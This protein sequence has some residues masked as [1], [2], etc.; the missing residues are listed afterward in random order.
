MLVESIKH[1]VSKARRPF[2]ADDDLAKILMAEVAELNRQPKSASSE[3]AFS[4]LP[5]RVPSDSMRSVARAGWIIIAIFFGGFGTWAL[6][7]PLNGAVVANGVVKVEGNRKSVQHLDGGIVKELRVKEGDVVKAGDVLVVLDESQAKAEYQVLTEQYFVLRLTEE[8]LRTEYSLGDQLKFPADLQQNANDATVQ[9]VWRTQIHQFE[10]RRATLDAQRKVIKEKVAQLEAQIEGSEA[11]V[12]AYKTQY[13][14]VQKERRTIEPLVQKGLIAQPRYLQ[15][16]RS[17]VALEGQAAETLANIAKYREAIAEQ[18]HQLVQLENDRLSDVAKD[19]RETQAK[20]LEV[21]PRRVNA[22]AVLSRI[23]IRAPY[24]GRVVG[25]NVFSVGGVINR[26]DKIL[27]IVPDHDSLILEAQVGVEDISEVHPGMDADIH[28]T[29]YKQRI[30]PV[31]HGRVLQVSADRL[32]DNR[33]G[34]PYYTAEI[35]VDE[36]DLAELPQVKLY[37]GM[38]ANVMIQTVQRTAFDYLVGPLTMS[39]Q[40]A[41]RQR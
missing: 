34:A 12:R 13:E 33:T 25:L 40:R 2:S 39:F 15:L 27:D 10:S 24:T 6:C 1:L 30:T 16:E 9:S 36:K 35:V 23:E 17:G 7:A 29:A 14:S 37:P 32:T 18:Q 4:A 41:F 19:L 31:V 28:L 20:L 8:R 38:P 21:I 22:Q 11:Q 3:G 5:E 26:G